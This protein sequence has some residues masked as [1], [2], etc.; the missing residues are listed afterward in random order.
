MGASCLN[1][2]QGSA[3]LRHSQG[4]EFCGPIGGPRYQFCRSGFRLSFEIVLPNSADVTGLVGEWKWLHNLVDWA[5]VPARRTRRSVRSMASPLMEEGGLRALLAGSRLPWEALC[6]RI[7]VV[8]V[9][10]WR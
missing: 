6:R 5:Q 2:A 4:G 7:A 8:T 1:G 3:S 9:V 10:G